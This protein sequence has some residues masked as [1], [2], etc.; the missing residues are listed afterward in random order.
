MNLTS[1]NLKK[2]AHLAE[3][4]Q[5]L[6]NAS[7]EILEIDEKTKSFLKSDFGFNFSEVKDPMKNSLTDFGRSFTIK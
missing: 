7:Q 2:F 6:S 1:D 5:K 4:N 3:M